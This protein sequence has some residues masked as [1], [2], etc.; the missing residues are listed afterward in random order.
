MECEINIGLLMVNVRVLRLSS[1]PS[2]IIIP[3]GPTSPRTV[4]CVWC[5]PTTYTIPYN[6]PYKFSVTCCPAM[7]CTGIHV[8]ADRWSK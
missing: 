5:R 2:V 3:Y 8:N 1:H 7:K 4:H 6:N